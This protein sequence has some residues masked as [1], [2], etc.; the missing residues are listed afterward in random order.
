[1]V[2]CHYMNIFCCLSL[3]L[4]KLNFKNLNAIDSDILVIK[5]IDNVVKESLLAETVKW[6]KILTYG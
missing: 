5:N 4:L 1:M 3:G 2:S 6:K